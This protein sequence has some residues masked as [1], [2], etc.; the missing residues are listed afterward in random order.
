MLPATVPP[1]KDDATRRAHLL[2]NVQAA[3]GG[4]R[5]PGHWEL[6]AWFAVNSPGDFTPVEAPEYG[7]LAELPVLGSLLGWLDLSVGRDYAQAIA[8]RGLEAG[9]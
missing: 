9:Q 2:A 6:H 3:A 1:P 8:H 4:D 5:N 7:E